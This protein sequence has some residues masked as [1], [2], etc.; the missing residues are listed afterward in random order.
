[1]KLLVIAVA[2]LALLC[3]FTSGIA[4]GQPSTIESLGFLSTTHRFS[5]GRSV[6]DDGNVIV[7]VTRDT[8]DNLRGFR[9][10]ADEGMREL[11]P[12]AAADDSEACAV[13][14][15]GTVVVGFVEPYG[16][17]A[18]AVRWSAAG[19]LQDV[20]VSPQLQ[21]SH[22]YGIS[23][24]GSVAVGTGVPTHLNSFRPFMFEASVEPYDLGL[25]SAAFD[26]S[27][28]GDVIVG[29]GSGNGGNE[30][31]RW[32]SQTGI[33]SIGTIRGNSQA[34]AVSD[35]G[36][37]I[38]GYGGRQYYEAAF[39]WTVEGKMQRLQS[40]ADHSG[41]ANARCISGDGDVIGGWCD[42]PPGESFSGRGRACLWR[43]GKTYSLW[44]LLEHEYPADLEGWTE[45]SSVDGLSEDGTTLTGA[46]L[47]HGD[48]TAFRIVLRDSAP[49][50]EA[51]APLTVECEGDHNLVTLSSVVRDDGSR[52]TTRWKIDGV[53]VQEQKDVAPGKTELTHDFQHGET[54]VLLEVEDIDF[55]AI[56]GTTVTVSD[57]TA[58]TVTVAKDVVVATDPLKDFASNVTLVSPRVFDACDGEPT[59]R[60]DAPNRFPLG[61]SIVEW[62][63]IDAD[64]NRSTATQRVRVEDRER[65]R[66]TAAP[67]VEL[68]C[69]RGRQFAT[70]RL[71]PPA[72][73]DNVTRR[74]AVASDAGTRFPIGR[75]RVIWK[76][77]DRAGNV[78]TKRIWVTVV[79]RRPKADAGRTVRIEAN[80]ERG[81]RVQLDGSRSSDPDGHRL[82]YLWRA[83]GVVFRNPDSPEPSAV[84]SLG[85]TTVRLTATDAP[86]LKSVDTTRVIV[87]LANSA[88]RPSG[89]Q[90]NV[91]FDTAVLA[92]RHA[93]RSGSVS[94]ARSSGLA[95]AASAQRLGILAGDR[96]VWHESGSA[97]VATVEY[98]AM[99]LEQSRQGT[100]AARAWLRAYLEEGDPDSF[101]AAAASMYGV[102][103]AGADLSQR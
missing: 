17:V 24:D 103:Y 68:F 78:A 21:Q 97:E 39:R 43:N 94:D 9:W 64:G 32:T 77:T 49:T 7:G 73:L 5:N 6:S 55:K 82:E 12:K 44:D 102:G 10:T 99:R 46:G 90:A 71:T 89:A 25:A 45:L 37:V 96:I 70:N 87:T 83:P 14:G 2:T 85:V 35:D 34:M 62:T 15:D 61:A 48:E 76:A 95:H 69:D 50:V 11:A 26:A 66:F 79:N 18:K 29:G 23:G 56:A 8:Y 3:C 28:H 67:N 52:V 93:V 31:F 75:T 65:P 4:F 42:M 53:V 38:V 54:S 80:S 100:S 41:Q 88:E 59:L 81:V 86:G 63:A 22:A 84:F 58:P 16:A 20:Y 57:T 72:A 47:Y 1:M 13:S 27:R 101:A 98:A 36:N 92:G 19:T 51:I 74:V 40:V 60:N 91:A 33:E 30:A